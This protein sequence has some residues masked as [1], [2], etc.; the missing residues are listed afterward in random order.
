MAVLRVSK[1][2]RSFQFVTDEGIIYQ[3]GLPYMKS[4][5]ETPFPNKTLPLTR[6]PYTVPVGTFPK[7]V[8]FEGDVDMPDEAK[9]LLAENAFSKDAGKMVQ[10]VKSYEDKAV[11]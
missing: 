1:S 4:F 5:V 9:K 3:Q 7:S 11:W 8:V 6:M 2:G 10:Q